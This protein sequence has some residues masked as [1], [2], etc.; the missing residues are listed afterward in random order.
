LL[1]CKDISGVLAM[2]GAH[3]AITPEA[4]EKPTTD[5]SLAAFQHLSEFA[6][7]MD[8]QHLK[9]MLPKVYQLPAEIYRDALDVL[10]IFRLS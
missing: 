8:P 5:V 1:T 7:E 9:A 2:I 3:P 10:T 6:Y 4:I